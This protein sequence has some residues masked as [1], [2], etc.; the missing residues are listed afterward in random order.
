MLFIVQMM[1]CLSNKKKAG[2]QRERRNS[3]GGGVGG[4]GRDMGGNWGVGRGGGQQ[5]VD[6]ESLRR[7]EA[8]E[9]SK[10]QAGNNIPVSIT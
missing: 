5:Q 2:Q 6:V 1:S 9:L 4:R 3:Q 8:E 7:Q 10:L